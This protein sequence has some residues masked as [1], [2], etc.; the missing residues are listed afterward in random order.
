MNT[1]SKNIQIIYLRFENKSEHEG[2]KLY[3]PVYCSNQ[4]KTNPLQTK[5]FYL[6]NLYS[7]VLPLQ[8]IFFNL[9]KTKHFSG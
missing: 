3:I 8:I 9:H 6:T 7:A 2:C 5:T 1:N 4:N